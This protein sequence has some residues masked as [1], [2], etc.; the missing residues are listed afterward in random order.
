MLTGHRWR[1]VSGPATGAVYAFGAGQQFTM[2]R[3]GRPEMVGTS[4]MP[5]PTALHVTAEGFL[6]RLTID[7]R[8]D[9]TVL[10]A[11]QVV[12]AHGTRADTLVRV[13]GGPS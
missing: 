1:F 9:M 13:D 11:S 4:E 6:P 10:P 12:F 2:A 8:F 3:R 7:T 5:S